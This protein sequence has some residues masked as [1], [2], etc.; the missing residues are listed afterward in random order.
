MADQKDFNAVLREAMDYFEAN[1]YDSA[2]KLA[3]W[4][5]RLRKA[6]AAS[7]TPKRKMEE[8]LKAAMTAI[9]RRLVDKQGI[10]SKHPGVPKFTLDRIKPTLRQE[11]DRRI[12]ANANLITLN[13]DEEIAATLRRFAGWASSI[14]VGGTDL[15]GKEE[16]KRIRKG[17]SGLSFRERRVMID[18][19]HKLESA[20]NSIVATAGGAIAAVWMSHFHQAGYDYREDHKERELA[21]K[22]L[23]YLIRDSWAL[24]KGYI[25]KAG[26]LYTDE[27]E[28]PGEFPYCRCYYRYIYNVRSMPAEMVTE[29]GRAELARIREA[30]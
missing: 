11:L 28:Q 4:M 10:L 1:G 15:S 30:A 7:M 19:G 27:I 24:E 21:S 22:R 5:E 20:I 8:Q 3:Y 26:S 23:P 9:Y 18:Q 14:P 17:L 13:K 29:K 6:A 2:E 25:K 16:A 12:M